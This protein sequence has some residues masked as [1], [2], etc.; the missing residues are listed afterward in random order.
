MGNHPYA[1]EIPGIFLF[2]IL[3]AN[4]TAQNSPQGMFFLKGLFR[5]RQATILLLLIGMMFTASLLSVTSTSIS[6]SGI[7]FHSYLV[8][9]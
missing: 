1:L 4:Q 8:C 7:D 9:E 6:A 5:G 2:V 3:S